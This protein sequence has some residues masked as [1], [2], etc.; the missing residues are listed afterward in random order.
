MTTLGELAGLAALGR[1]HE[2]RGVVLA[3]GEAGVASRILADR[4][5]ARWTYAG[6]AVAPGQLSLARMRDEFRVPAIGPRTRVFGVL[7]RPV[8]HSLSPVMHN[9]AFAACGLDAV[10]LPLAAASFADFEAFAAAFDV[11]GASVTAPFKIEARQASRPADDRTAAIGAV[12]TLRRSPEGWEGRNTDLD[13]FM[14]PLAGRTLRGRRV[15]VLGAGGAARSVALA[16][17][18][19]G[20]AVT[21]HARRAEAAAALAGAAGVTAGS[22]PPAAGWD[23]LVNTTPV[24]TAPDVDASPI[25]LGGRLDGA[26][27]YDLVYNP[28]ETALLARARALGAD[29]I[30]GLAMLVAQAEAQFA[31]W[32]GIT[33]PDGLMRRAA[34]ARLE[35]LA[36]A[37]LATRS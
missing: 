10:Y 11:E 1:Q 16:L 34:L 36:P 24:G 15:A 13:G 23:V 8:G 35:A 17:D 26:L 30:G 18:A 4:M 37:P 28:P 33:P 6:D 9:A 14:A 12:N 2:G 7:G 31:W 32:T 3:M 19:A 21:V 29:T 22:W 5:G 27:V 20:A 25:A